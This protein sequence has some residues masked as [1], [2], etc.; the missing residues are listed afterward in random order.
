MIK[1]ID[2]R[3]A[4][5]SR[6]TQRPLAYYNGP[7]TP[8]SS[9]VEKHDRRYQQTKNIE[10]A[11]YVGNMGVMELVKFH[12]TATPEQKKKFEDHKNKNRHK[13]AW[14]L[15]QKV[16]GTKLH[17]SVM[18]SKDILS[19]A[20]AGQEGTDELAKTYMKDTPGQ[21]FKSFKSYIKNK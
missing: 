7:G 20:G 17:K 6:K 4:F 3:W 15:V 5:V 2:G 13:D 11:S 1:L 9:W 12:K 16:T 8:P 18:E 10:E 21:N 14:N 19:K